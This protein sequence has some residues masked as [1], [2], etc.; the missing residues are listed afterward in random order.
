MGGPARLLPLCLWTPA[1]RYGKEGTTIARN[2]DLERLVDQSL[3]EYSQAWEGKGEER[4]DLRFA[5]LVRNGPQGDWV[6]GVD[7]GGEPAEAVLDRAIRA[8]ADRVSRSFWVVGPTAR[9]VDLR[10]RLLQR[11]FREV[12]RWEGLILDDLSIA[13]DLDQSVQIEPLSSTNAH[14]YAVR[15]TSSDDPDFHA[16]LLAA[17]QRFLQSD[18]RA[19]EL[20]IARLD[21]EVAG[22]AVLRLQPNGVAYLRDAMTVPAFRRRGVYSAL[23][24][25]RLRTAAH[26][27]ARVAVVQA[28]EHTSAPILRKLGFRPV[29]HIVGLVSPPWQMSE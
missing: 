14:E 5:T 26:H 13:A 27:G 9:P 1:G 10:E 6:V 23:V 12:V 3:I 24:A 28:L 4:V 7:L 8:V 18:D 15:C 29:C 25:H 20:S 22:Y 21:G 19:V 11:D 16:Y 17:A 2:H